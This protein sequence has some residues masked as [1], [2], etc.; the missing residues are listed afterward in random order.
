MKDSRRLIHLFLLLSLQ[1]PI[2]LGL[3]RTVTVEACNSVCGFQALLARHEEEVR[4]S[5]QRHPQWQN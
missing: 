2:A 1:T 4:N 3:E 5:N